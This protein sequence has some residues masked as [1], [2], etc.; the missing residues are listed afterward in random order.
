MPKDYIK[1]LSRFYVNNATSIQDNL[2]MLW[3]HMEVRGADHEDVYMRALGESL[4]GDARLW[5]DH[6]APISVTG[7]DMFTDLLKKEWGENIDEPLEP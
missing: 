4:D 3:D 2:Q 5:F 1:K 7:Y 6:L